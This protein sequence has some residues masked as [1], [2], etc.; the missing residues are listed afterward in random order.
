MQPYIVISKRIGETPLVVIRK[1]KHEHPDYANIPIA[2]AG[3]LDPMA[4]GKLLLLL[5]DECKKQKKYTG[6]DKEYEIEILL[7]VGSDTG[8]AL[9]II[10]YANKETSPSKNELQYALRAEQGRHMRPYPP[11]SSKTVEGKPLFLYALQGALGEITIPEHEERIY[12]IYLRS[13]KRISAEVLSARIE[14]FLAKVPKS[15]EPSKELGA[16]FRIDAVRNSW[17]KTLVETENRS[18][19]ILSLRISCASSTYMRSL[20]ARIGEAL[21]TKG[22]ALSIT[23][24]RIGK[25]WHGFWIREF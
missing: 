4:E 24:I 18:F 12:R 25:Y 5:G 8:D 10:E 20:S 16:N 23:R 9:G 2:Y 15:D 14:G 1:W 11:F 17:A 7:D 3:R 19:T 6:L 13:L 21:G 22:L